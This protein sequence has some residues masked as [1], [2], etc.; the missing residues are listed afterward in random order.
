[1]C[2]PLPVPSQCVAG[3]LGPDTKSTSELAGGSDLDDTH[4][5]WFSKENSA[6]PPHTGAERLP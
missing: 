4:A 2:D 5:A 1:M 3:D 6:G